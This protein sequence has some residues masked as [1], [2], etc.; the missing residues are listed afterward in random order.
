MKP[1]PIDYDWNQYNRL[2]NF[3]KSIKFYSKSINYYKALE[4]SRI[5]VSGHNSTTFV[6]SIYFNIPTIIFWDTNTSPIRD[7]FN[8]IFNELEKVGIF[9]KSPN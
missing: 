6:E 1:Y 9:H 3:S 7:S 5:C 2:I 4:N 8:P